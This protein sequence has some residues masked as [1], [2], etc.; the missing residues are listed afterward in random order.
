M[1]EVLENLLKEQEERFL[2][3]TIAKGFERS[4]ENYAGQLAKGMAKGIATSMLT[5]ESVIPTTVKTYSNVAMPRT[6]KNYSTVYTLILDNETNKVIF[7]RK[8]FMKKSP[9]SSRT[10]DKQINNIFR[11]YFYYD[12]EK[13]LSKPKVTDNDYVYTGN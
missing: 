6:V 5:V 13:S 4:N 2:L 10:I 9:V 3:V 11:D 7:Y 8:G 12:N 1:P